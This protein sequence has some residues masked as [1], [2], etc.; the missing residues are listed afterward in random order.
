MEVRENGEAGPPRMHGEHEG[1]L[2]PS[3]VLN[4]YGCIPIT[5]LD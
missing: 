5:L 2:A 3:Q 1:A 4:N